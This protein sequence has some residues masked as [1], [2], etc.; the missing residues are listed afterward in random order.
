M[1]DICRITRSCYRDFAEQIAAEIVGRGYLNGVYY[2]DS[3]R[4]RDRLEVSLVIYRCPMSGQVTD[5]GDIWWDSYT[6]VEDKDGEPKLMI[7]DFDFSIL[8]EELL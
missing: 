3:E 2:H 8:L 5:I 1:K 4:G 7:N 6:I